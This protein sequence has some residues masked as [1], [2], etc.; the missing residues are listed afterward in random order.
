MILI[1]P[2]GSFAFNPPEDSIKQ[3]TIPGKSRPAT[4]AILSTV[5]PGAGQV[6]NKKY[7]KVPILYAG[8]GA[9]IYF[10]ISNYRG[11]VK[12]RDAYKMRVD[13]DPNT[14][15]PYINIYDDNA[16]RY[17]RDAYRRDFEF[18]TIMTGALY[19]I[20]ILDAYVDAHLKYFDVNE[21]LALSVKPLFYQ[22][23]YSQF[24]GGISLNLKFK[25]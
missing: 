13:Q 19:V 9:L 6:Y 21:N 25:K 7:W 23:N 18:F 2:S 17:L 10:T 22:N 12:Y 20:N 14:V 4:A 3:R 24:A 16:L 11:Y 5:L 8:G 15:D 1:K